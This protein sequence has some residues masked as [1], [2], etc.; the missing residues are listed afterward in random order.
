MHSIVLFTAM[1]ATTGIFGGHRQARTACQGGQCA[2]PAAVAYA[3]STCRTGACPTA[4]AA[5]A[6]HAMTYAPAPAMT[7]RSAYYPPATSC[8]TGN[9]PRR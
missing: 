3:P 7:Y 9:C 4:Y 1:T 8:A 6:T 2:R 5:P